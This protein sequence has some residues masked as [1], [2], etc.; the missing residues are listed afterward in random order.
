MVKGLLIRI[1]HWFSKCQTRRC[2]NH[3][4]LGVKFDSR[5]T[6]EDHMRC[7]VSHVSQSIGVRGLWSVSCGQCC[8][9]S[10]LLCICSS[11]P[12]I[13][14]PV[15]GSAA[16]CHISY[17]SARCIRWPGFALTRLS[18]CDID[19]MLLHCVCC[20]RLIRTRIIVCSVSFHLLLSEFHIPE[21]RLQLIH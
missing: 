19:V 4:I 13:F 2:P 3:D 7:I 20:T 6:F 17:S 11:N 18:C 9:A 16:E 21:R 8:V 14:F 12:W 15:W 10:W 1:M 5:L